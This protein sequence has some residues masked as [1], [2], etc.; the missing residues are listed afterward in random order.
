LS[1][2]PNF[3]NTGLAP[4]GFTPQGRAWFYV[5]VKTG[6][7]IRNFGIV[8]G[9]LGASSMAL[10]GCVSSPT[11]G[12]GKTSAAQLGED[13]SNLVS[14]APKPKEKIDYAPRPELVRP[15]AG[16]PLPAPQDSAKTLA[17]A[18]WPESPEQRRA[19]LKAEATAAQDDPL[20]VPAI[21]ND[22]YGV[23]E[24]P[25]TP[26]E[27]Q[28]RFRAARKANT[29]GSPTSRA[30]LSEPP[31]EY[32]APSETAAVG[33]VGEDELKKERRLKREAQKKGG[34]KSWRDFVPWL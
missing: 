16:A 29:A 23:K 27:Q 14:I 22:G 8:I 6:M 31:L 19:R 26:A 4:A 2:W 15:A 9:L 1:P 12:T 7:A 18:N 30:F 5:L 17:A 32:R 13:V 25:L 10:A 33:E 28:A 3:V 20:F 34:G 24:G 21:K 11:Y